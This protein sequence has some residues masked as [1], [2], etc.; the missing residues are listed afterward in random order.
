LYVTDAAPYM[1]KSSEALKV[2]YPKVIPVTCMA[3]GLHR[4]AENIREKYQID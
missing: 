2:F 3:H 4:V 1:V